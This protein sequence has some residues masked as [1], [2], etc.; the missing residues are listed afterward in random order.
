MYSEL[1][2]A[3]AVLT[4]E[5][6]DNAALAERLRGWCAQVIELPCVRVE[7]PEDPRALRDELAAL[8]AEDWLVLTSRHGAD[9][10]A[11]SGPTRAAV[12]AVG[13]ATAERLRAHGLRV[14]FRP[15]VPSGAALAR[16]LAP[17][18]GAVLV[19][20]SDRALPDLP[21]ILRRRGFT[22]R[23]IV[24]YRTIPEA[25]GDVARVRALLADAGAHVAVLFHSP[26]AVAGMLGAIEA[27]LVAR[28][29]IH[30]IGRSTM[31]A[32]RDALGVDAAVSLFEEEVTHAAHR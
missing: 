31:R 16:E 32:V 1:R 26:S 7:P 21:A 10:V 25:H 15:S 22:V 27:P 8:R 29:S 20:R 28:A 30:V 18:A 6:G 17:R 4:R 23:E 13:E 5:A 9:A 19:A 3:T 12:A 2:G 24:A 14:D 11:R